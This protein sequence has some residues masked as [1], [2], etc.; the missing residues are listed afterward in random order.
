[1]AGTHRTSA[2]VRGDNVTIE[3]I[4]DGEGPTFVILP[5]YGRDSGVDYDP[6]VAPLVRAGWKVLRPQPRGIAGSKGPM[7]DVS[8]H[9]LAD[10]VARCVRRLG[11]GAAVVLGHAFGHGVAKMT[12]TDHPDL[13]KA[14][15]LAAAQASHVAEDIAK[16]P[17]I[18]GDT[19]APEAD[20][21]AALRK[22]FFAPRH[23]ASLWLDG[24]YPA[25]LKMQHAA[26]QTVPPSEYWACGD[27]PLLE[28]IGAD[29]PW[30]P[31]Q[32]W[33]ELHSEFGKR[34]TTAVIQDAS[35]ALF[36]EQPGAIADAVLPWA[37]RYAR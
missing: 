6:F 9:D 33:D 21:L 19:S 5:S 28:L 8:L 30:K 1:M 31:K 17:F 29:D 16:T 32:Y 24:W 7:T 25:T 15:I 20:R 26:A 10:D 18:A 34:V 22:A 4:I 23:D 13:V 36:P 27:V 37:A 35:H 14:V 3:T 2:L 11:D 12:T